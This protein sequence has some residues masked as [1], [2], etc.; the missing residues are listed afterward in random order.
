MTLIVLLQ[1]TREQI[2]S[3]ERAT[4]SQSGSRTWFEQRQMRLTAS[5][6]GDVCHRTVRRNND[7]LCAALYNPRALRTRAIIHGK[8]H[9]ADAIKSF[10]LKTGLKVDKCGLFIYADEPYLAATPDGLVGN[11]YVLEV[12]CPYAGRDQSISPGRE[13]PFLETRD[14]KLCLKITHKYFDQIQGQMAITGR[15]CAYFVVF[16][17]VDTAVIKVPF[18]ADFWKDSMLAKLKSFYECCYRSYVAKQLNKRWS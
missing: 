1:V 15:S 14:G 7:K 12:K 17:F 6:F 9:E 11:N 8:T 18:E 16:T 5:T 13:F 3:I 4:R 10:C 2:S